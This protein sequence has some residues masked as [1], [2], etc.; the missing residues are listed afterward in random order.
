M[1]FDEQYRGKENS[2]HGVGD[3]LI[4]IVRENDDNREWGRPYAENRIRSAFARERKFEIMQEKEL[5][6]LVNEVYRQVDGEITPDRW[7][8][9]PPER[10]RGALL[11]WDSIMTQLQIFD[12]CGVKEAL[13]DLEKVRKPK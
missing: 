13:R 2:G 10:L 1:N 9:I 12:K 4:R 11:A 5:F 8:F 7:G 3:S 6:G